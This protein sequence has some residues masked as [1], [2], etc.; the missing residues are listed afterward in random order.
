V[1]GATFARAALEAICTQAGAG[2]VHDVVL[3][4]IGGALRR[5]LHAHMDLPPTSLLA[6]ATLRSSQGPARRGR[7][8]SACL[9]LHTGVADPLER[10]RRIGA[11]TRA[12]S[13]NARTYLGRRLALDALEFVPTVLLGPAG[14]AM[15]AQVN[16]SVARVQGPQAPLYF[17][18]ARLAH[19][20]TMPALRG[21]VGVA[22]TVTYYRDEVT[23]GVAACRSVLPDP[24][25]YCAL[26]NQAYG[27]LI[28]WAGQQ[29]AA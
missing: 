11:D 16:T 12:A 29:A 26:L 3:A 17:A 10:L 4:T 2:D 8:N 7:A 21:A 14:R 5:H 6:D 15:Q 28:A 23:I 20:F 25:R 1:G 19:L 24:A 27:E 9:A 22:H 13:A 18:G